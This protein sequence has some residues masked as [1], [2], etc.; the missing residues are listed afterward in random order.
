MTKPGVI[1]SSILFLFLLAVQPTFA[2]QPAALTGQVSSTE[3]GS[4]EGVLEKKLTSKGDRGI[5]TVE[6]KGINQRGE[7]VCYFKRKVM[8]WKRDAGPKRSR[9]YDDTNIW[10]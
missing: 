6:T 10:A 5:V 7:E 2:A 8:V 9:P 3:E 1:G 4:M